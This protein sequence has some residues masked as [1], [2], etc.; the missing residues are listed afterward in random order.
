[1]HPNAYFQ[2]GMIYF[3]DEKYE[4][5]IDS[6]KKSICSALKYKEYYEENFNGGWFGKNHY[7]LVLG[8]SYKNIGVAYGKMDN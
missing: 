8:A 2:I 6:Y 3:D 7:N 4:D 1:M 5:G